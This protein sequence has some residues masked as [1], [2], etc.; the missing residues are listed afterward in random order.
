MILP[1]VG[2]RGLMD[3]D[4]MDIRFTILYRE[5][6]LLDTGHTSVSVKFDH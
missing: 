5:T 4:F 2:L 6:T 3:L 1:P